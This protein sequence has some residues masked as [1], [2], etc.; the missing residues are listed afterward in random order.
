MTSKRKNTKSTCSKIRE[1]AEWCETYSKSNLTSYL[2][3]L[4]VLNEQ[5]K[6]GYEIPDGKRSYES[7]PEWVQLLLIKKANTLF[8]SPVQALRRFR[9]TNDLEQ[10]GI[11]VG[12]IHRMAIL[13]SREFPNKEGIWAELLDTGSDGP[14]PK[15]EEI[16]IILGV[17]IGLRRFVRHAANDAPCASKFLYRVIWI[18]SSIVHFDIDVGEL[19]LKKVFL[20][21]F[22]IFTDDRRFTP[23]Q[24]GKFIKGYN[25]GF[26]SWINGLG[27]FTKSRGRALTYFLLLAHWKRIDELR[28]GPKKISRPKLLLELE[29]WNGKDRQLFDDEQA[30]IRICEEI[31]L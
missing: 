7:L 1:I 19:P 6:L 21:A 24:I 4:Y 29:D 11:L 17:V 5:S 12:I 10:F 2:G 3:F 25:R 8:L 16:A 13:F 9:E 26:K 14:I 30:F 27:W 20:A 31:K 15:D 22:S 28:N 23:T 18:V